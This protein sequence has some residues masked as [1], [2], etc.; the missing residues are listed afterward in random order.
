MIVRLMG[1]CLLIRTGEDVGITCF[2]NV[3]K[4]VGIKEVILFISSQR[5]FV[6]CV[7]VW[8]LVSFHFLY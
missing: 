1:F 8:V 3:A 7:C 2:S 6:V 5:G 4:V